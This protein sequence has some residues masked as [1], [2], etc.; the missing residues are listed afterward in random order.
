MKQAIWISMGID[1]APFWANLFLYF[2]QE[3]Y[4]PSLI[5]SD[6]INARYFHSSKRFNDV[7]CAINDGAEFGRSIC[8]IYPKKLEHKAKHQGDY[9][10]FEF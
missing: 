4:M 3:E 1:P 6:K 5:S 7:L 9:A 10:I 2:H 8:E